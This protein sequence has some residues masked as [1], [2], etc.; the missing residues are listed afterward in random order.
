MQHEQGKQATG[1]CKPLGVSH[2]PMHRCSPWDIAQQHGLKTLKF[3]RIPNQSLKLP[4]LEKGLR[5][6][7]SRYAA[8][9]K[10]LRSVGAIFQSIP[11]R[12]Y[13]RRVFRTANLVKLARARVNRNSITNERVGPTQDGDDH[14]QR[15]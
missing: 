13:T 1:S 5:S 8:V 9:H 7:D 6:G 2:G 4:H 12:V 11:W 10:L 15:G 14:A 3:Q